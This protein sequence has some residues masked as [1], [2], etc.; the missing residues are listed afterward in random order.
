M[1]CED[2]HDWRRFREVYV[3][4]DKVLEQKFPENKKSREIF[5]MNVQRK[6]TKKP[7]TSTT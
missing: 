7:K 2:R 3:H 4:V 5:K 1:F 6:E